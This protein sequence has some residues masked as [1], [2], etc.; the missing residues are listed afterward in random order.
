MR[1]DDSPNSGS[2]YTVA[3]V[4]VIGVGVLLFG[5]VTVLM[6]M[7]AAWGLLDDQALVGR[8]SDEV[9]QRSGMGAY[10]DQ[11]VNRLVDAVG[12]WRREGAPATSQAT[13]A[14][15]SAPPQSQSQP[16]KLPYPYIFA[17]IVV[18]ILLGV[19]AQIGLSAVS[20]G[21]RILL[22]KAK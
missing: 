17:W 11:Q 16:V 22:A 20:H 12:D 4:R 9:E 7:Q 15:A 10:F 18:T 3:I 2:S 13:A 8:V 21:A 6:V 5:L 14:A 19:I 1:P